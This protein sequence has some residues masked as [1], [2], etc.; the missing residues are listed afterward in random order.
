M[1]RHEGSTGLGRPEDAL[2]LCC[3][4][5]NVAPSVDRISALLRQELDWE[6]LVHTA[7]RHGVMPLLYK[8]LAGSGMEGVPKPV[9]HRL[10]DQFRHNARRNLFFTSVLFRCLDLFDAH[11]IPAVPYRGP[12]L[13]A[14]VYGDLDLRQ[15]NDLDVLV[16]EQDVLRA[17]DLLVSQGYRPEF[18]LNKAQEA[19]YLR[20]LSEHKV[21]RDNGMPLVVE[22]HWRLAEAYFAFPL[23]PDQLWDRLEPLSLAGREVQSF[24]PQDLILILC[25]H[26]TKHLWERLEWICDVAQLLCT[27]EEIDLEWVVQQARA[28]GSE[29]MLLLGLFLA[30]DLLGAAVPT[31]VL[32]RAQADVAVASL[33]DQV[34]ERLF[35]D[36]LPQLGDLERSLFH[37]KARERLE[38]RLRYCVRLAVT[39]TPGDWATVRLPSALFP[40]YYVLRPFRLVATYGPALLKRLL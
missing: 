23:N 16:R 35:S 29:R 22:L 32:Q 31:G 18:E 27:H 19:A 36:R 8:S 2:L 12:A 4:S 6:Y 9:S 24:S 17:R 13:A 30:N 15:F 38:D 37:L 26:G 7:L 34:Y 14:S 5:T 25:A 28:L 20:S 1:T 11:G 10:R 39:T 21:L 3:V 40:L 33:A